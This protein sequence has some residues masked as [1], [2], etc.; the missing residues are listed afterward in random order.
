[1][2]VNIQLIFTAVSLFFT[3]LSLGVTALLAYV[4]LRIQNEMLQLRSWVSD[5]FVHKDQWREL[6]Q[7]VAALRDVVTQLRELVV[8]IEERIDSNE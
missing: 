4:L 6:G 2:T 5:N 1:M 8:R 7:Q 3:L